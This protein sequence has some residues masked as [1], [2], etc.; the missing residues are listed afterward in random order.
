MS[1]Y[2]GREMARSFRTVRS[3]TLLIAEEIPEDSYDF[4]PTPDSR[5][6][7]ETLIHVAVLYRIQSHIQQHNVDDLKKV[8]F[9]ELSK[10]LNAEE[11]TPRTKAEIIELLRSEGEKFAAYLESLPDSFLA[12]AVAMPAGAMPAAKSRFE[13]LL[14]V[15]EHEMHHRGQLMTAQRLLGQTPHITR[16]RQMRAQQAAA[17]AGR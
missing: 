17:Q 10:Q 9:G 15:K 5:S 3:N 4:R 13:M 1:Y 2:G 14:S 12:E 8:N 6:V 7:A 16:E 11:R